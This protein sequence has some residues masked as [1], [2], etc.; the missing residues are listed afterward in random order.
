MSTPRLISPLLD[1][2]IMG[3][4]IFD[5]G[6]IR[7]LP[8]M[9]Q[10][11]NEKYIV[12]IISIPASQSQVDA[13]L[14]TG[15]Y[16]DSDAVNGYF[17][18][19]AD[20]VVREAGV[21]STLS[22]AGGFDGYENM[23]VVPMDDGNG[24]DV[25]LL[26]TYRPTWDRVSQQKTVTQLD[27]Y[28]MALD[29]CAALSVARRNGYLYV[30]LKPESVSV[31]A[32]GSYR[33]CDLGLIGLE[34]LQY[35]SMPTGCFSVYT[36][37]E[38]TDAYSS[39][40]ATIDVYALGMMLYEL[41]N[42]GLPFDGA[43]PA[44]TEYPAP[45]YAEEEFGQILLKAIHPNPAERWQDPTEMG[46]AIVSVM[47][48]K[49]VSDAPI[50]PVPELDEAAAISADEPQ[51]EE[52]PKVEVTQPDEVQTEEYVSAEETEVSTEEIITEVTENADE[53][54]SEET[55][56]VPAVD[57]VNAQEE[58]IQET[59][60]IVADADVDKD[61]AEPE[62]PEEVA[63]PAEDT[64]E[65]EVSNED[66]APA[67]DTD[68]ILYEADK[69]I[70]ALQIDTDD[71]QSDENYEQLA[72]EEVADNEEEMTEESP[73]VDLEN[74][75]QMPPAKKSG[76][77]KIVVICS[78]VL[79]A[80]LLIG[81][82]FFYRHIYLQEIDDLSV[83]GAADSITIKV[84]SGTESSKLSVI[85]TDANGNKIEA[86]LVNYQATISGLAADT[87]Y[88]VSLRIDGFHKLFGETE[89]TYI[90]PKKTVIS[91]FTVLNGAE[92]G[93]AEVS[94][95]LSGP[96]DGIWSVTFIGDDEEPH[97]ITAAEGKATVVGL[98]VGKEY[99]VSL[100][101]SASL[102]LDEE[103]KLT[104]TPGPV[105]KPVDPYI[106]SCIDGKLTV[107]WS[108]GE[109]TDNLSW[110]VRCYN[111]E[112]F[113]DEATV[114]ET[115]ATF[116]VPD[117]KKAYT[118]EISAVGQSIKEVLTVTENAVTLTGFTVDTSKPGAIT[119]NWTSSGNIP[120]GGYKITYT[121]DDIPAEATLNT[122]SNSL[123]LK[124]AVP[125][126]V[127]VFT[128][129]SVSGQSVL[130]AP[131]SATATGMS[132]YS[133]FGVHTNMLRFNLCPRPNKT[134]WAYSDVK[135]SSYTTVF[136]VDQKASLVC[137]ILTMYYTSS[138]PVVTQYVFR[139]ANN[140]VVHFC[141]VEKPWGSNWYNG[142]GTFDIPS[143][144]D[145]PGTYTMDM[146]FDGGLVYNT[147]ITIK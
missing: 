86:P 116:N 109:N 80:L 19:L 140:K 85:C 55:E 118:V 141:S 93:S 9:E 61:D 39:L 25:Y 42:G 41:F 142:F 69:L 84:S 135:S 73:S 125:N 114:N 107:V 47:Q 62:T 52:E 119:L 113:S 72:I 83:S 123:T 58:S 53:A 44:N 23:Q 112:G 91:D 40:N 137:R 79:A 29:L 132:Y 13:L 98:T 111:E 50:I 71:N 82:L 5:Q 110:I 17:A 106:Q 90:S 120:E 77:R 100:S 37:P 102:Y 75:E 122:T 18:E 56:D 16:K 34:Y 146:Y 94:Y 138:V 78:V 96:T 21:L 35:S 126:A 3:E 128:F 89:Y 144:P 108:A 130:S 51:I 59:D 117:D 46:Q 101:S 103:A 48:R 147:G 87:E 65:P 124:S 105:I 1:N 99:T 15:A 7:I 20:A 104:F 43:Q 4:P 30:N 127:H 136:A 92:E 8:A 6:G 70:A 74:D 36:A 14:I 129:A 81:G 133:N 76:K 28:N 38:I 32:S 95:Q 145:N 115:A 22:N 63:A 45:A 131:V 121:V 33:I 134:N 88:T 2:F 24:Y 143:L 26:A 11:K 27:G 66:D 67:E 57:A 68:D 10:T 49:G 54:L 97:V 64:N 139:D 12:K 31:S 60:A